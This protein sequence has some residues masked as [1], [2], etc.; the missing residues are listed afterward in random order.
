MPFRAWLLAIMLWVEVLVNNLVSNFVVFHAIAAVSRT[1]RMTGGYQQEVLH[2]CV[3]LLV[4]AFNH[5]ILVS[6][7]LLSFPLLQ[8][9]VHSDVEF[10]SENFATEVL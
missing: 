5:N 7:S 4:V 9:Q 3:P 8:R 10:T 2:T 6:H 1:S